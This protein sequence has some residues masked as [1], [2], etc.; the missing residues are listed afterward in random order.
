MNHTLFRYFLNIYPPYWGTGIVVKKIAP[1]WKEIIVQMKLRW[2]NRNYVNTH[3]GGSLYLMTDPFYMV[4]LIKILGKDYIV[5]DKAVHMSFIKPGRGKV[6]AHFIVKEEQLQN[7]LA[8]TSSGKK[9][10]PE[11]T[12]NIKDE[13]GEIVTR[14]TKILYIRKKP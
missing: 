4:M 2:Y 8:N 13:E 6:T 7:I 10:L 14:V 11:F 12:V 9:Y 3:F 1:D 5:W